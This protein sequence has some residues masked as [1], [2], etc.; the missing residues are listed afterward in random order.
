MQYFSLLDAELDDWIDPSLPKM[1]T[2]SNSTQFVFT[3]EFTDI[4]EEF[5]DTTLMPTWTPV[6]TSDE[7]WLKTTR[8]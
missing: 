2:L 7:I 6:I 8:R 1:Y 4:D 5:S 3:Y